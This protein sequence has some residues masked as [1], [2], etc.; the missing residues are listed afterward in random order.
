MKGVC[1]KSLIQKLQF[2]LP[3]AEFRAL[4]MEARSGSEGTLVNEVLA[5]P[6]REAYHSLYIADEIGAITAQCCTDDPPDIKFTTRSGIYNL[7]VAE[8]LQ[9][10]RR[11]H[12]E[13][14]NGSYLQTDNEVQ[15]EIHETPD[16]VKNEIMRLSNQKCCK[17]SGKNSSIVFFVN[18]ALSLYPKM[19]D[20][21]A[22]KEAS[23]AVAAICNDV[24]LVIGGVPYLV[25]RD[26]CAMPVSVARGAPS[27][28]FNL[29]DIF[30]ED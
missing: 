8:I 23:A 9:P 27:D 22:L 11:R 20:F 7:E 19:I 1:L 28:E 15:T 6:W 3:I 29:K 16:H 24:W 13:Y 2:E 10:N 17:L 5:K 25:W 12:Q 18:G 14:K 4:V 26:N 30:T 21:D